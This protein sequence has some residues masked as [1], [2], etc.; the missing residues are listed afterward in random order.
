[1]KKVLILLFSCLSLL[2]N[3]QQGRRLEVLFLGDQGHH[4]PMERIP[5]LMAGLGPKGI[6]FTYTEDLNDLN[7]ENLALY[8]ALMIY[9]NWN[10]IE[11]AQEKAL[12]DFVA[13]G[14]GL[15]PLHCAS[16][17]FRNSEEYV[18]MVGGQ[19]WRHTMDSVTTITTDANHEIMRGLNPLTAYDETYLHTK[20]QPDNH[21]LAVR[22]IKADQFNDKPGVKSEPY[23][24]TRTYGKGKVFYTAYGHDDRTWSKKGFQ[25]LIYNAILWSVDADAL[26]SYKARNPKPFEYREAKLPNYEQRPG[27][28]YQQ[29][30]L[31][32]EESM[33]H[34]Q[35]PAGFNLELFA[36]EPNV[37]HPIA[38]TWDEKGRLYVL[39]TKDYPNERKPEGGSDYILLCED[40]NKDG[41]ADRFTKFAE[42]LSIPTGMT[43][44]NGGLIVAQAPDML[45]LK[46]TDGDNKADVKKVLFTGWG[47]FDTHAGP[48]NLHYGFDNWVWGSVGYSGFYGKL[49]EGDSLRFWQ[50]FFRFKPDGSKMEWM[51]STNNNTWGFGFNET[52]DV[53]GSTANNSHGWYMAIPN[54]YFN[55]ANRIENG[56]RSTD[57]HR[58]MKP[59]TDKVRQVDAFG[60]FTAA[61]G[62]NFYTARA[63]PKKYWNNIAFVAEPTGHILHQNQPVRKGTDF[64]DRE[65]FNLMAGADEWFSPV[66]AETGPDGAVWVAD[67]YSYII[68]HNPVPEGFDNGSGNAYETNLRDFTHGRIYRVSWKKA[69]IYKPI[70][71][72]MDDAQGLLSALKNDNQFWR[73]Q[74]QRL[75]VE[76]GKTDV[77]AALIDMVKDASLD[78]IGINAGAIHA[79]WTL[80]GLNNLD[81]ATLD[82]ALQHPSADV[83]K[84]ALKTMQPE[85][86]ATQKIIEL[87][88]IN[89]PNELVVL[90][91]LLL[92]SESPMDQKAEKA[93]LDKLEQLGNTD[94]RWLP[95]AFACVLTAN[96]GKL[97][98]KLLTSEIKRTAALPKTTM[99]NHD[100]AA[101]KKQEAAADKKPS[102]GIDLVVSEIR[103]DP[104]APAVRDR[105]MVTVDITN[106]G[107]ESL[108]SGTLVPFHLRFEGMGI[109]NEQLSKNFNEGIPAGKTVSISKNLNGP[110]VGNLSF[111]TDIV[112][113]YSLVAQIDR[114]NEIQES[115][116]N[117][118]FF[119]KKVTFAAPPTLSAF[120]L[121]R[122]ARSYASVASPDSLTAFLKRTS[123][124][125]ADYRTALNKSVADGWN[126]KTKKVNISPASKNWLLSVK[127]PDDHVKRLSEAWGVKKSAAVTASRTIRIKTIKDAMKY[128]LAEFT[129]KP[130]ETIE[131]ILENPD[132]MQ[133]NLVIVKPG[134]QEKVGLAGDKM[135]NDPKGAE[136]NYVPALPEVLF[137][138]PLVN[139]GQSFKMIIK[140][141]AQEGDYPYICTFPAH[142]RLMKGVMKVRK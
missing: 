14:K 104:A 16:Y 87:N 126:Y 122:A 18:K 39:I 84:N 71:L 96:G 85:A 132:G 131:L 138:T 93:V 78:E 80:K 127:N 15:L 112:G 21:V 102:T 61:A 54:R 103:I 33:K 73:M 49:A 30:P 70:T 12:I 28:Q 38:M 118:N 81:A 43:F 48:S 117:N 47:T 113:E 123:A 124:L 34:I 10:E 77:I 60:G 110:W 1:M 6:N 106:Q 95:D 29:L 35:I 79:L 23:T 83:V 44:A 120:A 114:G 75:L 125:P 99:G 128:D 64:S 139:S 72:S 91:A 74:A 31:P 130:G 53:F 24:W 119:R 108:P 66:F 55:S 140:V 7:A 20:L 51:T 52:N 109:K 37:Q 121:Q 56:S 94:D 90:N 135:L 65:S 141:P 32:P 45:Y 101:M 63:F 69:P 115:D 98:K 36:A 62:H 129:A 40:T 82:V 50:A 134:A 142:W 92:L 25:D 105:I 100:H 11:P 2:T 116:K 59:I 22:E 13:S 107:T 133:H 67:W 86:A 42:G 41:K 3:A 58:D 88:L 57:T 111:A 17:C 4:R 8:D 136:K 68:Q 46:D 27:T 26:S 19:F 89:H 76:R 5:A 97:M 9:A 137:S